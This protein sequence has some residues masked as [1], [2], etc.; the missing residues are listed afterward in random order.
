[1]TTDTLPTLEEV[2]NWMRDAYH[3]SVYVRDDF[4]R[5]TNGS[6]AHGVDIYIANGRTFVLEGQNYGDTISKSCNLTKE[7]LMNT[8]EQTI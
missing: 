1:M 3:L 2:A 5:I 8:I 6:A 7:D 4:V